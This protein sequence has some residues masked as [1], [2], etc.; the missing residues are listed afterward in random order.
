MKVGI[1]FQYYCN[2]KINFEKDESMREK[3][4]IVQRR[5]CVLC[6]VFYTKVLYL[7]SYCLPQ[8]LLLRGDKNVSKSCY[9]LF[10]ISEMK[11][12]SN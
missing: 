8:V 7:I 11:G 5:H 12:E 6:L 3:A 4:P 9:T 1:I 2:Q 10:F